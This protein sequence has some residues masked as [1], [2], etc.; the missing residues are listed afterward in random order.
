MVENSLMCKSSFCLL[1]PLQEKIVC[2]VL[3]GI[4]LE[5]PRIMGIFLRRQ[6]PL[7]LEFN[8]CSVFLA[9]VLKT[10]W[11]FFIYTIFNS[12]L[13]EFNDWRKPIHY[14]RII[15]KLILFSKRSYWTFCL[16]EALFR[17]MKTPYDFLK[18]YIYE[19]HYL[20]FPFTIFYSTALIIDGVLHSLISFSY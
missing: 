20:E 13:N 19:I 17:V 14:K 12:F 3:I 18:N 8:I 4:L 9:Q 5:R 15:D 6:R 11:L 7:E 2:G 10:S 16:F 1:L